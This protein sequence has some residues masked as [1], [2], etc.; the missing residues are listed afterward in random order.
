MRY[1][2]ALAIIISLSFGLITESF[3]YQSTARLFEDDYDL[4]FDPARICEIQG[5][6]L[7]TSLSNFVT[8]YENLFSNGSVPYILLGGETNLG[9]Y[10]PG[11]VFDRSDTK[12]ALYTGLDDPNGNM[13][14][15]DGKL[16][17]VDWDDND[18][19]NIYDQRTIETE[20]RSAYSAY[21]DNDYYVGFGT[22]LNSLRLGLGYLRTDYENVYTDP[23][24]NF[25]YDYTEE[26]LTTNSLTFA[27]HADFAGDNIYNGAE[28]NLRFSG[29]LDRE[30]MS[31]G[32]TAQYGMLA[33]ND[34]AVILGDSTIYTDPSDSTVYYTS[35]SIL[36]SLNQ[37]Q[38]GTEI[39][40]EI[41]TFYNYSENG[42][43]RFYLG[44]YT[45]SFSYAD[46]AIDYF[47]KT[48]D[49]I[50]D[51]FTWDTTTTISY[52]DGEGNEKGIRLGTKQ[53]FNVSERLKFGLGIFYSTGSYFDSTTQR[54]T[55]VSV[56]VYDDN[57]GMTNDPDDFVQTTWSSQTWMTKTTGSIN[58]FAIPVGLEFYLCQPLVFRLGAEHTIS[59][60]DYTTVTN[61][62]QY[63]PERTRT[64]DG[65]GAVSENLIDPGPEPVGSEET[66]TETTP[67]TTY[68]YGIGWQVN[69]NLQIDLMSFNEL[70]DL[71]NWRL[72]AT[73]KF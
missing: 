49:N 3:R 45:Q 18:N 40:V 69:K 4:L 43:G 24:N 23:D 12:E 2:L 59:I 38:S 39:D 62:I 66:D 50:Y 1:A 9:K 63:E 31:V 13:M 11:I 21:N 53:L 33:W 8:G 65:T 28:N 48:R 70:T 47:Y 35:A 54:D 67:L 6:R 14:F 56:Q 52:Y 72:S 68:Y 42:Q 61:L 20:T 58:S 15:G 51:V 34:K 30:N 60:D 27:S 71:S 10:Y 16:S 55:T 44:F 7:W 46:D 22:K 64:V 29:W 32:L 36:D 17:T 57:D 19:N 73:L 41:K 37:P 26:D 5:S 25:I